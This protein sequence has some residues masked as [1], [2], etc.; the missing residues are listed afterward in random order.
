MKSIEEVSSFL[1]V[2][3]KKLV[4]T[5]ICLVDEKPV[6]ALVRG[7]HELNEIKLRNLFGAEQVRLAD[8]EIVQEIT[9]APIGFAG[10]VGL[11]IKIVADHSIKGIKNFVSD[12]LFFG[13]VSDL[14]FQ[15]L[16]PLSHIQFYTKWR[17]K[18]EYD[19]L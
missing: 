17:G 6:A 1:N 13:L 14:T 5:L 7:D 8:E 16:S 11:E 4:K 3:P 19:L 9:G 12:R 2:S 18:T 15:P 10:P